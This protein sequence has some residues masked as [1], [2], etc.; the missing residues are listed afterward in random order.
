MKLK[1]QKELIEIMSSRFNL[2]HFFLVL[3][4][5][6][7]LSFGFFLF[8]II[9]L[10]LFCPKYW[11]SSLPE[12]YSNISIIGVYTLNLMVFLLILKMLYVGARRKLKTSYCKSYFLI[13]LIFIVLYLIFMPLS[14]E[15]F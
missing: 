9:L 14:M 12:L 15:S 8:E 11:S 5:L 3:I 7:G 1:I 2:A 10:W 13:G 6:L 4:L